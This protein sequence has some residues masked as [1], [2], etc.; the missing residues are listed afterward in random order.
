M[1]RA[2]DPGK[3]PATAAAPSWAGPRSA[4]SG[5][6]SPASPGRIRLSL[7][8]I[9]EVAAADRGQRTD[10]AVD[11]VAGSS[12]SPITIGLPAGTFGQA[13]A[14]A[15]GGLGQEGR[16]GARSWTRSTDSSVVLFVLIL[17][18]C[19]LFVGNSATAAVR[20]R[21]T[22]AG[23]AGLPGLARSRLFA[24]VLGEVAGIGLVAGLL[25][26][27]LSRCRSSAGAGPARLAGPGAAGRAHPDRRGA[28]DRPARRRPGWP[29]APSRSAR[30]GRRCWRSAAP[31]TRP[32]SPRWP[33][34]TWLRTP[35]RTLIGAVSLAVGVAA[36]TL[37]TAVT[38]PS[39]GVVVGIAARQR[40]RGRRSAGV[41]YVAVAAT[42]ILGVLAVA[43]VL[44]LNI[45]ERA[46]EL[47][48][49]RGS[50][51]PRP[52]LRP[53]G[54]HRGRADRARRARSPAPRS[55][56]PRAAWF[57]G[58]LPPGCSP[59]RPRRP[60]A[61]VLVTAAAALLPAAAAPP[62]ARRP[63]ARRGVST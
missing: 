59:P 38:W 8:R 4:S 54:H 15:D 24:A 61:G 49:I 30:S 43:D 19:V 22:R 21:R 63:A 44:F 1:A 41:D 36:L 50:A 51:G 10:L 47:A 6:G 62:P 33:W 58:Q 31:T 28:G 48:T 16:R 23:R 34:S 60:L 2:A 56:W 17:V 46:A 12:P 57:A 45:T 37:L 32:G 39:A 42:V 14:A 25:G 5:S 9:N 20:G 53:A 7:E 40:R 55:G 29:P 18:V 27:L 3:P 52:A 26:A 13:A 35:G 11:I